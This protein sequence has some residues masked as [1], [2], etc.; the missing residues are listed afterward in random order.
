MTRLNPKQEL[1][2]NLYSS[3]VE[4]FGNGVMSYGKAYNLDTTDK[5]QY[6]VA[7][8]QASILLTNPIILKRINELMD[9][10]V[11]NETVDKELGFVILQHSDLRSKVSAIK[12]YNK[13]KSRV[14]DKIIHKIENTLSDEQIEELL[15]RRNAPEPTKEPETVEVSEEAPEA[16][17]GNLRENRE[18]HSEPPV[19]PEEV[20]E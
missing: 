13:L 20:S 14:E 6:G 5:G 1:F 12:E 2:C 10:L 15:K 19:L 4:F 9:I 18:A 16:P 8:T 7:K 11:N 17:E 3:S